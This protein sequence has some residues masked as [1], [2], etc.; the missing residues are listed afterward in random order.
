MGRL[1]SAARQQSDLRDSAGV[2][3]LRHCWQGDDD[4]MEDDSD[5]DEAWSS[6]RTAHQ[7]RRRRR[8][9]IKLSQSEDGDEVEMQSLAAGEDGGSSQTRQ[10]KAKS[11][12][13]ANRDAVAVEGA[14]A[15]ESDSSLSSSP[16]RSR[17][18]RRRRR[19]KDVQGAEPLMG[20]LGGLLGGFLGMTRSATSHEAYRPAPTISDAD[21]EAAIR[22]PQLRARIGAYM[23]QQD[24]V[25]HMGKQKVLE[26]PCA[27]G[28]SSSQSSKCAPSSLPKL[29][30]N[31]SF[32]P[33]NP[34]FRI[35]E[36]SSDDSEAGD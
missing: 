12:R 16:R 13:T 18:S 32:Y 34:K 19:D 14:E 22:D 6:G 29:S 9:S 1:C 24:P 4:D 35:E 7:G 23:G 3:L 33:K 20:L 8:R 17:R 21:L 31:E 28:P 30:V 26:A 5:Q 10:H 11:K 2:C 27:V 25:V 15:E 36:M